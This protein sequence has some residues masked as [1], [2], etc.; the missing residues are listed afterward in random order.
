MS[1]QLFAPIRLQR[2]KSISRKAVQHFL[3]AREAYEDAVNTQPGVT[4][5]PLWSCCNGVF[6]KPLI[7]ARVFGAEVKTLEECTDAIIKT[8]LDH[9]AGIVRTTSVEA[10]FAEVKRYLK[11]DALEPDA[12]LRI[13]MLSA[14]YL[15]LCER[16]G[17]NFVE[18]TPEAVLKHIIWVLQPVEL[19]KF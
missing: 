17:W 1:G 19:K 11:L 4:A 3:A 16:R 6:L 10:A 14:S 18:N 15:E 8:K 13:I 9:I 12:R 2:I 7:R 5:I